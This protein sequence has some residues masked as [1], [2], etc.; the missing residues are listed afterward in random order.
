MI[1][2]YTIDYDGYIED[3]MGEWVDYE[4]YY[5]VHKIAT[6]LLEAMRTGVQLSFKEL[7][8]M[9]GVLND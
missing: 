8:R 3:D 6:D 9:E 7:D 5:R 4:D 1:C 2:R